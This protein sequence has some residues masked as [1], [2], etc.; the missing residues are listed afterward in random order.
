MTDTELIIQ[1][2]DYVSRLK[3]VMRSIYMGEYVTVRHRDAENTKMIVDTTGEICYIHTNETYFNVKF[4]N[5]GV[6][7]SYYPSDILNGTVRLHS[8]G[9]FDR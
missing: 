7:E 4:D 2:K 9:R 6:T 1:S 8:E 5:T 3:S